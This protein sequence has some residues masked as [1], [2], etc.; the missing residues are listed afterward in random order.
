MKSK[1]WII[2]LKLELIY[3]KNEILT[4]YAN[5]VDFGSNAYGV[6]TACKTY[7]NTT[8]ANITVD[9]ASILVGMLKATTLYNPLSNPDN[10]LRRRNTVMHN[11]VKHQHLTPEAYDSL[12]QQPIKLNYSVESNYDG[13]AQYFRE[14]VADYLKDWC[15]EN[16]YDLYSSGLKIYTTI[17]TRMQKYAEVAANKQMRQVQRN[18]NNHWGN[19]DPW[20]DEN[21]NIIPGFIEGIVK[22]QPVYKYLSQRFEGQPDSIQYYLNLATQGE[23]LRLREGHHRKRDEH[24]RLCQVYGKVYALLFCCHGATNGR[25]ESLGGRHRLQLMEIRQGNSHAP[26]RLHIQALCIY[27]GHEPGPYTLRQA[28]RRVYTH[29]GVR[30]AET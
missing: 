4:M 2:A 3:D 13:Q 14:A 21:H 26:A 27:R 29:G 11:M 22:K 5:T 19:E 15:N 10:S 25:R 28:P 24:N 30:Q 23:T 8:P 7:F 9:Q 1:E 12:S 6:K 20:R 16:G 17:D 18:F